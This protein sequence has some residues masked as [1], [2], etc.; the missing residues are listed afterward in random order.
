MRKEIRRWRI[1]TAILLLLLLPTSFG[2]ARAKPYYFNDS[3]K[4]FSG[5]KGDAM[6]IPGF[7]WVLMSKGL[8]RKIT[9]TNP[10]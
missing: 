4:V 8:Y 9:T 1:T 7:D 10:Q 3:D 2:C 5:N 6:P